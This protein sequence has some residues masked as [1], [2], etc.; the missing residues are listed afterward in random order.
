MSW[1]KDR[2]A[3]ALLWSG[4]FVFGSLHYLALIETKPNALDQAAPLQGWELPM[5]EY[6]SLITL[7]KFPGRAHVRPLQHLGLVGITLTH[8]RNDR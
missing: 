8:S 1:R 6:E 2:S 5:L 3:S 7:Q 4:N